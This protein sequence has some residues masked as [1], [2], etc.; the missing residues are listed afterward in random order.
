MCSSVCILDYYVI[1]QA[2][3]VCLLTSQVLSWEA[4]PNI[5]SGRRSQFLVLQEDGAY[6]FG[7]DTGDGNHAAKQ[8]GDPANEVRGHYF[9]KTASGQQLDLKYTSGVGGFKP[10]GLEKIQDF[11][12]CKSF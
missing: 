1:L 12:K 2:L 5:P 9:Y 4:L 7:Y 6:K 8:E 3:F 10:E 11:V